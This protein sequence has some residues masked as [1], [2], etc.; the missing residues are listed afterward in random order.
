MVCVPAQEAVERTVDGVL[1]L[2]GV[3]VAGGTWRLGLHVSSVVV[4]AHACL[5]PSEVDH[6][7]DAVDHQCGQGGEFPEDGHGVC[8]LLV[9]VLGVLARVGDGMDRGDAHG[10]CVADGSV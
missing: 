2:D 4:S 3:D 1:H 9:C 5:L 10:E 7:D 6:G 8:V